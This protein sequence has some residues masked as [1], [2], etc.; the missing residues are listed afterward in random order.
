LYPEV[1]IVGLDPDPKAL[2]R[3]K[4]KAKRSALSIRL[5]QG[6][7]RELPYPE[8][9]FDRVLSTFMFHHLP[10]DERETTLCEVRRVLRPGGSFHMLDFAG[11]EASGHGPLARY[12]HSSHRLKHSFGGA[13][14]DS[15]ESGWIRL[16]RESYGRS[17]ALWIVA[18]FVLYGVRAPI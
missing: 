13:N 8:A 11:A 5:D 7:S 3:A 12:F 9:S 10:V 6:F 17:H 15:H 2:A 4:R 18:N 16:L 14:L 1:D